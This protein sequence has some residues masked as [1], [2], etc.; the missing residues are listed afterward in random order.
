MTEGGREGKKERGRE[1]N[2]K[3]A[4]RMEEEGRGRIGT[5]RREE[6]VVGEINKDREGEW[7]KGG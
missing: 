7:E 4:R 1:R 6:G 2:R 3:G 5:V